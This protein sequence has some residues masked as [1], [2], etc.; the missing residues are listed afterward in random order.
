MADPSRLSYDAIRRYAD[1]VGREHGVYNAAGRADVDSLIATLGGVVS[2]GHREALVVYGPGKFEISLPELTSARRDRFTKAHEIGHYFLH[3][4]H[5]NL[6]GREEFGRGE[7]NTLE[8]QANVFASSL[9]MPDAEF[10]RAYVENGGDD[11]AIARIFDVSPDAASVRS[12][13][14]GLFSDPVLTNA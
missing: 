10:R 1:R 3:Y 2:Y 12:Q 5:P 8:T 14:L 4:R 7:R 11:W 9:L 13:V 6:E